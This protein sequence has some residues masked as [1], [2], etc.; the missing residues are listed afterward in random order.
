MSHRPDGIFADLLLLILVSCLA[1]P[2]DRASYALRATRTH[3]LIDPMGCS[4]FQYVGCCSQG[5]GVYI[6]N[7]DVTFTN[8]EIYEN[9]AYYVSVCLQK[10][11]IDPGRWEVRLSCS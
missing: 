4:H 5:G 6:V 7:G 10:S 11:R 1:I 8:C 3:F 9:I 2:P